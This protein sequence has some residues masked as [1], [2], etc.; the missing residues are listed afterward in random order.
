MPALSTGAAIWSSSTARK[1]VGKLADG[2]ALA[3]QFLENKLKFSPYIGEAV[4]FGD[5]RPFVAAIVAIDPA[6]VGNW[7]ER[8]NLA[9]TSF[10][11][12]AARP[13]VRGLIRDEITKC[14]AGVPAADPHPPL[15][16]PEQ[17]IRRRRRR[18]HPDPQDPPALCRREI[19]RAS[20]RPSTAA[21]PRSRSAPRSPT[22]TAARRCCT[23]RSRS[24]MSTS[25]EI[26]GRSPRRTAASRRR[27]SGERRHRRRHPGSA[28][29]SRAGGR[30][31]TEL[32]A[33][34]PGLRRGDDSGAAGGA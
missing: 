25:R 20:S 10:Q 28:R 26:A 13:E 11:D 7:A 32:G 19:R 23:R 24:A 21:P 3:P 29:R 18:D 1:D 33:H 9:Y 17:G 2:S 30:I 14:N 8:S 27:D 12:L 4:V 16:G 31:R 22:R 34:G 15:P 6:T 5:G